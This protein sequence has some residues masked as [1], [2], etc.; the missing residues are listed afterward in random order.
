MAGLVATSAVVGACASL[1][2]ERIATPARPAAVSVQV[3]RIAFAVHVLELVTHVLMLL[4]FCDGL[5]AF[6]PAG[7]FGAYC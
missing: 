1:A 3:R 5:A 2:G 6:V 7:D 4:R